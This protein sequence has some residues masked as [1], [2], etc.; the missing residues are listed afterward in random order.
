MIFRLIRDHLTPEF[1]DTLSIGISSSERCEY[2]NAQPSCGRALLS[3]CARFRTL[4]RATSATC[5]VAS[6][7]LRRKGLAPKKSPAP[8]MARG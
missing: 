5:A 8:L 4:S 2:H 3:M 6:K 7:P 1:A